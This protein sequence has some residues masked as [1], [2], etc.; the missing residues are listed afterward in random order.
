MEAVSGVIADRRREPP[1]LRRMIGY[2]LALHAVVAVAIIVVSAFRPGIAAEQAVPIMTVSL[3]GGPGPRAGGLNPLGGRPVQTTVPSS[4]PRR[5][6]LRP[7]AAKTP[8]MTLPARPGAKA[9]APAPPVKV[10]PDEAR[11]TTPA[12][13]DVE[14]FG[15]AIAETAG[16]GFGGL[17]TGGGSGTRGLID[18]GDF[19]CPQYLAL[20]QQQIQANWNSRQEVAGSA[21]I[22]FRIQRDGTITD[23]EVERP[24]GY[25]ALDYAAQRAL[26]ATRK[27]PP[28]PPAFPGTT[29]TVHLMFDYMR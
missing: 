19:C 1:G 14:Q 29:L 5:E 26:V 24:S 8:E 28:L 18:E 16:Q 13:G 23:M 6:P 22:K 12:R 4:S 27:L 9:A 15:S 17:S 7:P 3:A 2:S 11:G 20:M 10:A 21:M 25:Y